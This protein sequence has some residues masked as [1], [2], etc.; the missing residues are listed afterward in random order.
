MIADILLFSF[1][2]APL[3]KVRTIV[4]G[5]PIKSPKPASGV[6]VHDRCLRQTCQVL[7]ALSLQLF[8]V[9]PFV[10]KLPNNRP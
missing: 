4:L 3:P 7:I 2:V 10:R 9:L 8:C 1:V 5:A 6:G